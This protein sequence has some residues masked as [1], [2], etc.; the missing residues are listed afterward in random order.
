MKILRGLVMI[1]M[2]LGCSY[3]ESNFLQDKKES[4]YLVKTPIYLSFDELRK[5]IVQ[6]DARAIENKGVVHAYGK[7]LLQEEPMKGIHIIDSF[8]PESSISFL[9]IYGARDMVVRSDT[10]WV[11][12]YTDRISFD[13]TNLNSIKQIKREEFLFATELVAWGS[14]DKNAVYDYREIDTSKGIIVAWNTERI[15][16]LIP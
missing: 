7:H 11:S 14:F 10:L 13:L 15:E 9:P 2:L 6:V 3:S 5:P 1:N 4:V 8:R 12:S 16:E